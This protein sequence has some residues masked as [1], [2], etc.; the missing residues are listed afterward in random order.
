[1]CVVSRFLAR[2]VLGFKALVRDLEIY[3]VGREADDYLLFPRADVMR[4]MG[5]TAIH[6][7]FKRCLEFAGLPTT[8]KMHELR[9]SA[10]DNLWRRTGNLTMAQQLLRH[11]SPA[12][13]AGY[14]HPTYDD[15]KVALE[16]LDA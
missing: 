5:R 4:P 2:P 16:S 15:L 13:T 9:H 3:L 1:V 12:T 10:A 6:Y 7:W 11:V 14:L 8:I